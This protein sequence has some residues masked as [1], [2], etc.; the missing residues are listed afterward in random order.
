M[1]IFSFLQAAITPVT[2]LIDELH[3]SDEEREQIRLE[4]YKLQFTVFRKNN[5]L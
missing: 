2:T 5:G 3:T 4:F 1:S